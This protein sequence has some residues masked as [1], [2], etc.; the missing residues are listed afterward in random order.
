MTDI[1]T[2]SVCYVK[3]TVVR[4]G[5]IV[6][7]DQ[8]ALHDFG[9]ASWRILFAKRGVIK[10]PHLISTNVK[11]LKSNTAGNICEIYK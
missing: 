7:F 8:V 10:F 11:K 3:L 6:N 1:V 9:D 4:D 5:E 2:P